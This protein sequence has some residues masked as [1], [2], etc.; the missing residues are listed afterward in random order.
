MP[1]D[2]YSKRG[3]TM[4]AS[5][6]LS[7]GTVI[8]LASL[9][10]KGTTVSAVDQRQIT[11]FPPNQTEEVYYHDDVP[12]WLLPNATVSPTLQFQGC[13]EFP[14]WNREA[15]DAS[16]VLLLTKRLVRFKLCPDGCD[17]DCNNYYVLDLNQYM[18]LYQELACRHALEKCDCYSLEFDDCDESQCFLDA[19][20]Q[21]LCGNGQFMGCAD[22]HDI[23]NSG[24]FIGPYCGDDGSSIRLGFFREQTCT[25]FADRDVTGKSSFV[26]FAKTKEAATNAVVDLST[27]GKTP[28]LVNHEECLACSTTSS[29]ELP[30]PE[31][32]H[33]AGKCDDVNQNACS[34]L[35]ENIVEK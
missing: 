7:R 25:L 16:D 30:C 33:A 19:G 2:L 32:Y 21:E 11:H 15:D 5:V 10:L 17:E 29:S 31:L 12:S 14:Q 23:G 9:L 4:N 22:S 20:V 8:V 1:K 26:D 27:I 3:K 28:S 34:F 6:A 35:A 24:H 18:E 13:W